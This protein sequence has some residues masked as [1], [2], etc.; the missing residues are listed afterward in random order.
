MASPDGY[1]LKP[2]GVV[3]SSLQDRARAP[4][5]GDEVTVVAIAGAS[6]TVSPLEA[7]D[8]TPVVDIKPVL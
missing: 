2:I 7:I 3:R 6:L 4:R 5:Q 1:S 8:G